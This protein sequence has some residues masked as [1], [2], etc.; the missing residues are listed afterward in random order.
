MR[1]VL[2]CLLMALTFEVSAYAIDT[3]GRY[4]PCL[5]SFRRLLE[6]SRTESGLPEKGIHLLKDSAAFAQLAEEILS[7]RP[8]KLP[9]G[10]KFSRGMT[11]FGM[12][13]RVEGENSIR[14]FLTAFDDEAE[15]LVDSSNQWPSTSSRRAAILL[16]TTIAIPTMSRPFVGGD[17]WTSILAL[18]GISGGTFGVYFVKYMVESFNHQWA[19]R[20]LDKFVEQSL[21]SL[22]TDEANTT[23]LLIAQTT[24]SRGVLEAIEKNDSAGFFSALQQMVTRG[25]EKPV[26]LRTMMV[27]G[28][29]GD[30]PTLLIHNDIVPP[31]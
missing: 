28:D 5:T 17:V 20:R 6:L 4:I 31:R 30:T 7:S 2:A 9:K 21:N 29:L 24:V 3:S 27:F 10:F 11:A 26:T 25:L 16:M 12:P 14:E 18:A 19:K 22:A 1:F 23:Q 15:R 13:I 8:G